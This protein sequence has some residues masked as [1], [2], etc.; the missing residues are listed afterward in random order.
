MFKFHSFFF[1]TKKEVLQHTIDYFS[2]YFSFIF[3]YLFGFLR[4]G[5]FN[6]GDRFLFLMA[7]IY[8]FFF[9]LLPFLSANSSICGTQENRRKIRTQL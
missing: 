4:K 8:A 9:G 3:E 1:V 2:I 5:F 6:L 7:K